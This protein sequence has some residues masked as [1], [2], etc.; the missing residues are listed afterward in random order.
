MNGVNEVVNG[1]WVIRTY[2]AGD[3]G[4]KIAELTMMQV[5]STQGNGNQFPYGRTHEKT[6]ALL[7]ADVG[8][9]ALTA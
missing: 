8:S 5:R 7:L 6:D 3:V 2:T 1:Y 9:N 4:E